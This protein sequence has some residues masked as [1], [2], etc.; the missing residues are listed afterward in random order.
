MFAGPPYGIGML[1]ASLILAIM[2]LPFITV[3]FARRVRDRA[4]DA[5]GVRLRHRLHDLGGRHATS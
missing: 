4:A 5:Q 1:T 3:D 2:V